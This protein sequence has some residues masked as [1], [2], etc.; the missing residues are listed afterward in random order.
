VRI[1]AVVALAVLALAAP[2]AAQTDPGRITVVGRGA[3]EVE[4]DHAIVRVGVHNRAP[5]PA[6]VLDENSRLAA[7]VIDFAKKFGVE[8]R[9]LRTEAVSL[10]PLYRTV[11]GPRDEIRQEPDGF[12]ARNVVRV[13]IR[14]KARLGAFLRDAVDQGGNRIDGLSFVVADR[15]RPE[16]E[17]RAK[18]VADAT[19]KAQE[20]AAAAGVRLGR[21]HRIAYG[22]PR[23]GIPRPEGLDMAMRAA[24][25]PV[26]AGVAE[27]AAEVQ[28]TW[29][30][31][32]P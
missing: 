8:A 22:A 2:A 10:N 15:D 1:L 5:S 20:I 29:N 28:I 30:L 9:D 23:G 11:R 6:A 24:P 25:V 19:R 3:V 32:Q 31:E 21:V 16:G 18:A 17:A 13:R 27:I 14:D 12:E 7:Q 26:E 4:P